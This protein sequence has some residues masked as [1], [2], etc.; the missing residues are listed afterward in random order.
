MAM[1]VLDAAYN[2]GEDYK[3]GG[4]AGLARRMDCNPTT[5]SHELRG[6]GTAKLGL[7]TAV[8]MSVLTRDTRILQAFAAECGHMLVPLPE[9]L[10]LST[11]DCIQRLGAA[12]E[13]F[14]RIAS[15][16][17]GALADGE[18][19]ANELAAFRRAKGELMNTIHQLDLA[20]AAKHEGSKP[21]ELQQGGLN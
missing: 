3:D 1:S 9:L 7:K 21:V 6:T 15:Q 14:G 2:V 5:L 13:K 18:V 11:D 16:T 19:N 20:M 4:T 8:K 12:S 10:D 17:C